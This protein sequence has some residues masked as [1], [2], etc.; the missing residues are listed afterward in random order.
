MTTVFAPLDDARLHWGPDGPQPVRRGGKFVLYWMQIVHRA[1]DNFALNYAVRRANE[2]GVPVLVYHGLRHDYPWAS[3]RLHTFILES[4]ADLQTAFAARG[5]QYAFHLDTRPGDPAA[6]AGVA[7]WLQHQAR[8]EG[9][10]ARGAASS[11]P[12]VRLAER[13]A[14][15][16]TDW[17]PTFIIPRQTRRLRAK[18]ETP[19]V[20]VDSQL[21]VPVTLL[22]KEHSTARGIRPHLM[23]R[24]DAHLHPVG[25]EQPRVVRPVELPF[26]PTIVTPERIPALVAGCAIDHTV[27]PSP[28]IRGGTTAA[29]TR[30]HWWLQHGLARY[31]E[32][33]DPNVDVTSR[34]SPYLHFGNISVQEVLLAAR[35]AG[36]QVPYEKFL[37]E[38]VTWRELSFN[39]CHWNPRHRTPDAIPGWAREQLH[40]HE[41][42]PRP[43]LFDPATLE[44]GRTGEHLWDAMQ[45][46]YLRDGWMHNYMRMLWGKTVL[47]WT[48]D[49]AHAMRILE[50]LNNKYSLDGRN[51]NSYGGIL[52]TFG[53][54]DRPFHRR[55]IYGTVRYQS[56]KAAK[57]KFDVPQ[58][59]RR[60]LG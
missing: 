51:P 56:L 40:R 22:E 10:G 7:E 55:P 35:E 39:L 15:V 41:T 19:V 43:A 54:F 8:H 60:F 37:D 31:E 24:L 21:V 57:D 52:W 29:R 58:Y 47:Q 42:D 44:A 46:S 12:L 9:P 25:D 33:N 30:L 53:K 3:D 18:T 45:H 36:P 1:H 49:A 4:V 48:P 50:H 17:F 14:L 38:T 6:S 20:A 28:L 34:L 16:V 13:A 2:L 26:E 11:S 27:P 5:I 23:K 32:R 59:V